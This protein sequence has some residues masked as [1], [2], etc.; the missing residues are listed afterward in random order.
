VST[1]LAIVANEPSG[2]LLGAALV[3]ALQE[4]LPEAEFVGVAGPHMLARGCQSL[5]PQ[6]RLSVM[7]LVE[8]LAVLPDL[9]RARA[10]AGEALCRPAAG[11]VHRCRR[12]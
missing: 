2:D 6:E 11:G 1:R 7:G 12:P 4:R 5:M 3:Q 8:V 10:R 9:L